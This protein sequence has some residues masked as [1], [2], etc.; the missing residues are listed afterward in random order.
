MG[1]CVADLV[2]PNVQETAGG[3]RERAPGRVFGG[4]DSEAWR[5]A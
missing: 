3:E 2:L 1:A 5:S 4:R